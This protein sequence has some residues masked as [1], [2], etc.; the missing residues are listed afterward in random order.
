M[1]RSPIM[2]SLVHR[3]PASKRCAL[4]F[5]LVSSAKARGRRGVS[6]AFALMRRIMDGGISDAWTTLH[7]LFFTPGCRRD[8]LVHF[9]ELKTLVD[10]Y[11]Q[12]G[13]GSEVKARKEG[14]ATTHDRTPSA[15]RPA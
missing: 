10:R 2:R 11:S 6:Y 14:S 4:G 9:A 3:V 1:M 13:E 12:A 8:R 5:D 15:R 7:D